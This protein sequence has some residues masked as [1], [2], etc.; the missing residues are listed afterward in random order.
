MDDIRERL[1]DL[2]G[3]RP[4]TAA[5]AERAARAAEALAAYLRLEESVQSLLDPTGPLPSGG[6]RTGSLEGQ[7]LHE[8]AERVL[9]QAGIPLHVSELGRRIK[10]GGWKHKRSSNPRRDQINY[11]LAARLP[12]YPE[13]FVRVAPNT[14]GLVSWGS[15]PAARPTPRLGLFDGGGKVTGR[16]IGDHPEAA[17]RAGEWR[18]S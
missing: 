6:T 17:A 16:A 2:L 5:D 14:F 12:R 13:T 1:E 9:E 3:T 4:R 7:T 15:T 8:A 10:A 18:S 11:Q